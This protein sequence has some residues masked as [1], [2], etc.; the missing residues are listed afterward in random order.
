MALGSS[1]D[2]TTIAKSNILISGAGVSNGI[3]ALFQ[4]ALGIDAEKL[5]GDIR[6]PSLSLSGDAPP[7]EVNL[8][9]RISPT[10]RI[11]GDR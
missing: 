8:Q 2:I 6:E 11:K 9:A 3:Q 5:Y 4:N 1:I 7:T 10:Q